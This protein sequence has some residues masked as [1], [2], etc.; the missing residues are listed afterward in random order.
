MI[1]DNLS[2]NISEKVAMFTFYCARFSVSNSCN[3]DVKGT[4]QSF[5]NTTLAWTLVFLQ[6]CSNI[7]ETSL[8]QEISKS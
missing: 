3:L 4:A 5:R 1:K 8:S 2:K 6:V 7:K